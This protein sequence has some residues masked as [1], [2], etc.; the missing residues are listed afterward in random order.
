ML[1]VVVMVRREILSLSIAVVM[2]SFASSTFWTILPLY[3]WDL[4]FDFF[5]IAMLNAAQ[6][7]ATV[8]FSRFF[9]ILADISGRKK[10][11]LMELI[12][13][14]SACLFFYFISSM[15][16]VDMANIL[17]LS[18]IVGLSWAVGGGAVA[19]AMTTMFTRQE[20]GRATGIYLSSDAVGWAAGSFVSGFLADYFGIG[21]IFLVS[22]ILLC[23]GIIVVSAGYRETPSNS[24]R[25]GVVDLLR[26][27][28]RDSWSLRL[29]GDTYGLLCIYLMVVLL[30]IGASIYF[31]VF[32]IKFYIIVG[33]K[34]MYGIITGTAG[35][36][37]I[38]T[39]Y[40]V[41]RISDR[42]GKG[43]LLLYTLIA[44]IGFMYYLVFS[45][46]KAI[47]IMFWLIPLWGI[48]NLS[49]ISMTTDY[50]SEGYES[51]AQAIRNMISFISLTVGNII[52]GVLSM[53]LD[54]RTS[55]AGMETVLLIGATVYFL[56]IPL[57]I[58]MIRKEKTKQ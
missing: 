3:M 19:A 36:L 37:G 2:I 56:S 8:L 14:L 39:P 53:M 26:G 46:N 33:T 38:V 31:L 5:D 41:G 28:L 29:R 49:L 32:V 55:T 23:V 27:A 52:G 21:F 43:K 4:G 10:F 47:A 15:G 25:G 6:T 44:R 17:L 40:I 16:M 22:S 30:N 54:L 34:T 1:C 50:A 13:L 18:F 20:T 7:L 24:Y 57:S 11:I 51:E 12:I 9:G 58:M 42:I 48:I 45:W 35:I